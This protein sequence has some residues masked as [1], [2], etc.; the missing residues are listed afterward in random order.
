MLS[1]LARPQRRLVQGL[2]KLFIRENICA[3]KNTN[4]HTD[5]LVSKATTYCLHL[6]ILFFFSLVA[7]H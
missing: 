4:V 1:V 5:V 7:S 2:S 3:A 6:K